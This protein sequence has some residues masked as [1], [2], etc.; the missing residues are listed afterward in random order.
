MSP[1]KIIGWILFALLF[2]V[3]RALNG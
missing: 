2:I 1:A 3:I